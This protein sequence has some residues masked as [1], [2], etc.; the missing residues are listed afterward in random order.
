VRWEE[1]GKTEWYDARGMGERRGSAAMPVAGRLT[2]SFG[3]RRH[4]VLGFMRMHK[5][6]DIAAPHG[7][8]IRAAM[9]GVVALAGRNGGYGNFV[10]LSHGNGLVTGYGHMSRFAVRAGERVSRGE[11]IGYVGSTGMSTGPHLHYELWRNGVP[12]NPGNVSY[13]SVQQLTG[14]DLATFK[15]RLAKLMAV[16]AGG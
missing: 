7:T 10:K 5:G 16:P 2:S 6:L 1:G 15:A 9:D 12:V 8:P 3:F 11:I 4:P 13:S 14:E